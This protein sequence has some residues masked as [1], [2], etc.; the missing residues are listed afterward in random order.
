ML[1]Q[2]E[3]MRLVYLKNGPPRNERRKEKWY[4]RMFAR[5]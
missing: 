5:E 4:W 1:D 3:F 2:D